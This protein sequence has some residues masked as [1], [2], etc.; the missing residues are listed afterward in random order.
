MSKYPN[1]VEMQKLLIDS[2]FPNSTEV[3]V[4]DELIEFIDGKYYYKFV[5]NGRSWCGF[6]SSVGSVVKEQLS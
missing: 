5:R 2:E 1:F 6:Y 4:D 3:L